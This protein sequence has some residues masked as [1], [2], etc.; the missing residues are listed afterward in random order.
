MV[1]EVKITKSVLHTGYLYKCT[2]N[3]PKKGVFMKPRWSQWDLPMRAKHSPTC[4][5][6][7]NFLTNFN[8]FIIHHP[9]PCFVSWGLLRC[10]GFIVFSFVFRHNAQFNVNAL[11]Y[12][13]LGLISL[14]PT[15][16]LS[17]SSLSCTVVS[18]ILC[19]TQISSKSNFMWRIFFII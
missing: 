9:T 16:S 2:P 5:K 14:F 18:H 10:A 4:D 12:R 8:E 17:L 6:W 13:S 11:S 7:E 15:C 1:E 19:Y 3:K